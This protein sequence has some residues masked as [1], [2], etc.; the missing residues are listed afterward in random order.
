MIKK[1]KL[2][3]INQIN[4]QKN[5]IFSYCRSQYSAATI[6]ILSENNINIQGVID[7]NKNFIN[8]NF[9]NFKTLG[10]KYIL[11]NIRVS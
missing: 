11:K 9:M 7:D 5:I 1:N 2:I 6:K 3:K 10:S 4:I 8:T